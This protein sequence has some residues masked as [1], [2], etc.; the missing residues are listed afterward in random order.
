MASP[1]FDVS[2]LEAI[3]AA[4]IPTVLFSVAVAPAPDSGHAVV[5]MAVAAIA[6]A[7]IAPLA[8]F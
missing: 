7:A 8:D 5:Q 4:A 2:A 6:V 1:A 3:S